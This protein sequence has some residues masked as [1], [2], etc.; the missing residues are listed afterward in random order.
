MVQAVGIDPCCAELVSNAAVHVGTFYAFWNFCGSSSLLLNLC[1]YYKKIHSNLGGGDIQL[2][3]NFT[4]A[5]RE[6]THNNCRGTL[7]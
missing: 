6:P 5:A 7:P 2:T 3:A 1:M 4:L